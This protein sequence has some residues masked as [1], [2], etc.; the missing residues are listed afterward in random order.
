[1]WKDY[2]KR[3]NERIVKWN[4]RAR[5]VHKRKIHNMVIAAKQGVPK[6]FW[7]KRYIGKF[8]EE[9]FI[10]KHGQK[11]HASRS[12]TLDKQKNFL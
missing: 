4:A 8:N 7:L 9:K 12:T 3:D 11:Q 6:E 1:M 10:K 2:S 5:E